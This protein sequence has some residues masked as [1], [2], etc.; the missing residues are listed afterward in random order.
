[1]GSVRIGGVPV[2]RARPGDALRA[3]ATSVPEDPISDAVVAGL[4]VLGH[5][6]LDGQGIPRKGLRVD[7]KAVRRRVEAS[8]VAVRLNLAALGRRVS[9]LSGGNGQRVLLTRSFLV[10]SARLVVVAYPSRGLDV[11][12]VRATQELL[13]ERRAAGAG[14]LMVSEDL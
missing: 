13:L 3:G 5:L 10:A 8:D 7:W 2:E 12:S 11:A 6:A 1:A 14:V 9:T 4:D